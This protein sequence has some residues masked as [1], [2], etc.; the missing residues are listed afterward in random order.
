[1]ARGMKILGYSDQRPLGRYTEVVR[2][3]PPPKNADHEA[4]NR[5][6]DQL[7]LTRKQRNRTITQAGGKADSPSGDVE[8]I[9]RDPAFLKMQSYRIAKNAM[10]QIPTRQRR[11]WL[12]SLVG[13]LLT[14][15]GIG[16][17][18]SFEPESIPDSFRQGRGR[19]RKEPD[20]ETAA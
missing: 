15:V 2:H 16:Q 4:A 12:D 8:I 7:E 3:L 17:A 10:R 5:Y 9:K 19:P 14:E 6:L 13:M 11:R 1:M 20:E 18:Q